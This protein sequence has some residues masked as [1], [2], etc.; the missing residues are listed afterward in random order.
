MHGSATRAAREA[1]EW[2]LERERIWGQ[3]QARLSR[4][5][6]EALER[7]RRRRE[8]PASADYAEFTAWLREAGERMAE[9]RRVNGR[10]PRKSEL[11]LVL[12]P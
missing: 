9:F 2:R 10:E 3:V 11:K 12:P 1:A 7:E 4:W 8:D 5:A 6:L